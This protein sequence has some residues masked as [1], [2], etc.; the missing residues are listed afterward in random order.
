MEILINEIF[1]KVNSKKF[2]NLIVSG[3]RS[4]LKFYKHLAKKKENLEKIF[5]FLVD[6][7]IVSLKNNQSNYKTINKIFIRNKASIYINPLNK[8]SVSKINKRKLIAL[9]KK[10]EIFSVIGMGNDGHFASIF[11]ES[12]KFK[13]LTNTNLRPDILLTEKI[14][15]PKYRRVTMNLSMILMSKKI[16]LIINNQKKINLFK[17]AI[18]VKNSKIYPIYSLVKNA[19]RKLIIYDGKKLKKMK[20]FALH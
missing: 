18:K 13:T 4:P 14:G 3:G 7:R 9:L 15:K 11:S 8:K 5:F 6:E 20:N 16:Y 10:Y 2:L 19:K 1:G 12:K 17:K